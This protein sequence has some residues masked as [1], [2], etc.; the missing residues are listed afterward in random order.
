MR[1]LFHILLGAL[2]MIAVALLS[3]F[4]TMRLVIHGR[5][6]E[7]PNL[8]GLTLQEAF[9]Q[10]TLAG[11]TLNVE[12]QFYST[13]TP[14]GRVLSQ[15]PTPGAKVRRQWAVRVT[16][17]LGPQKVSVP[18]LIG[19]SER[20]ATV[21]IRRLALELGTVAYIPAPGPPGIVLT[22]SPTPASA[23]IDGPRISLLVSQSDAQPEQ[24]PAQSAATTAAASFNLPDSSVPP[25]R[26]IDA[27]LA[28]TPAAYV[29]PNL[30][31]LS[32]SAASERVAAIG[33]HITSVEALPTTIKPVGEVP[34]PTAPGTSGATQPIAPL[35]PIT[36]T[37]TVVAQ[38]PPAGRRVTP[39]DSIYVTLSH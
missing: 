5:E 11:L 19:Q 6:V 32:L 14:S 15:S 35:A 23:G 37:N 3:A 2:A 34:S 16:E 24:N 20:T 36:I 31:G 13:V 9:D 27:A 21:N 8:A 29:M 18:N 10:A 39:G 22:Q 28:R 25:A 4:L 33:L 7:V 12:N 26:S 38:S 1:R 30:I 17:S